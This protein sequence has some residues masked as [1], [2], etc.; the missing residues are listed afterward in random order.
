MPLKNSITIYGDIFSTGEK[1][2]AE[3]PNHPSSKAMIADLKRILRK[4]NSKNK[5]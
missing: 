3:N 1:W 4:E 2:H 5:L